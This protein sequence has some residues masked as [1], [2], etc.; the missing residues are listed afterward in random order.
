MYTLL[1]VLFFT[2]YMSVLSYILYFHE[3]HHLFLFSKSYFNNIVHSAGIFAYITNFIIQFFYFPWLGSLLLAL[4][5]SSIYALIAYIARRITG[6]TDPLHLG[7]IP[8]VYLFIRTLSVDYDLSSIIASLIPLCVIA[9]T[10]TFFSGRRKYPIAVVVCS[11]LICFVPWKIIEGAIVVIIITILSTLS[12]YGLR[13]IIK[14]KSL[15][16]T[17]I[18]IIAY[19]GAGFYF[20]TK[21]F[22][23]GEKYM[24]LVKKTAGE[25]KWGETIDLTDRYLAS[26]RKNL[27]MLY[28]RNIALFHNGRL[29]DDMFNMPQTFGHLALC[30]PWRG[31]SRDT[32]YGQD[33]YYELEYWNAAQRWAFEAMVVWGETAPCLINLAKCNIKIK[34]KAVAQK[35]INSLNQS[36]FYRKTAEELEK[37]LAFLSDEQTTKDRN[38]SYPGNSSSEEDVSVKLD[39]SATFSGKDDILWDLQLLCDHYPDN[40]M[41]FEYFMNALL[42]NNFVLDFAQ[43]LHRIKAF[44]YKKMPR[45]YDEALCICKMME[46]EEFVKLGIEVS[47]ET[48]ARFQRYFELYKQSNRV[49]LKRE[50]ENSYWYYIHFVN[51]KGSQLLRQEKHFRTEVPQGGLEH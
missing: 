25:K 48:E 18:T 33:A 6:K 34:R 13:N 19:L 21:N 2:A 24:I 14:K 12:S 44:D 9:L 3:Q 10:V 42:L 27:L 22:N 38:E 8:V 46:E 36:A 49:G 30:F 35:Y 17:S 31:N 5:L 26:G 41:A 39:E 20:F 47:S 43:N 51:P 37:E 15:I 29:G 4:L 16:I 1:V 50:F 23:T 32:E 11:A 7:I 28:Y 45:I 40:K